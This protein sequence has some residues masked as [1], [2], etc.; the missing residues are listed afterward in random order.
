[1]SYKVYVL[2]EVFKQIK[3]LPGNFKQRVKRYIDDLESNP[4]PPKSKKLD[5][6]EFDLETDTELRRFRLD[7]W[8]I[9]Y[10]IDDKN[11]VVDVLG[12]RKRP[13][14]DYGDLEE[15]IQQI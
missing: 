7:R 14:Y 13:P 10:S 6:S 11:K 5:L 9:I 12:I 4:R 1:M 2:P 8:R 3:A 15:L